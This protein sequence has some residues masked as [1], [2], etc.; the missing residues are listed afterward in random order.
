MENKTQIIPQTE[1]IQ[2][3]IEKWWKE[4]S[5]PLTQQYMFFF[6]FFFIEITV[7]SQESERL[8][9]CLLVASILPLSTNFVLDFGNIPT[10]W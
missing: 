8:C 4:N 1:H 6:F 10:V 7:P 9:I 3:P 5:R 2:N